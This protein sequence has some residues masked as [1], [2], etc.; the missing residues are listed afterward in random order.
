MPGLLPELYASWYVLLLLSISNSFVDILYLQIAE[1]LFCGY[2]KFIGIIAHGDNIVVKNK[3]NAVWVVSKAKVHFNKFPSWRDVIK[4][5]C[6]TTKIK[7]IRVEVETAFKNIDDEVLFVTNQ[8]S[9]VLDLETRKIRKINTI[10]Y[11]E[12]ME[13]VQSLTQD[14]YL[15]LDVEFTED[16]LAY[17][18]K[19]YSQDIDYSRHVNN[20]IYVRY[21][22]NALSCDFF[23]KNKI[24]DFEIHYINESKEGQIL[25]IYKKEENKSISFLIKDCEKEIIRANLIFE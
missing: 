5:R 17:E 8:E 1:I 12:D 22:M 2:D 13:I 16:D 18:Q 11:P 20:A 24:T 10:S 19:I 14:G 7:P 25:K 21:I 4:G 9:C 6:Y 3:D 23:N 15:K